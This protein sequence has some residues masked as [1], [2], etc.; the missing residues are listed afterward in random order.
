[1]SKKCLSLVLVLS[2]VLQL[3]CMIPAMATETTEPEVIRT[4]IVNDSF[5]TGLDGWVYGPGTIREGS[6]DWDENGYMV[7]TRTTEAS[8][9]ANT[10]TMVKADRDFAD[11]ALEGNK[12]VIEARVKT[13]GNESGANNARLR[14]NLPVEEKYI[15][16]SDTVNYL[17]WAGGTIAH[18]DATDSTVKY[19]NS[20][21]STA[22]LMENVAADEWVNI[23]A[24]IDGTDGNLQNYT[25]SA[26]KDNDEANAVT[27]TG[28]SLKEFKNQIYDAENALDGNETTATMYTALE[29]LNFTLNS[30]ASSITVD[31]IRAYTEKEV[32]DAT[33]TIV[34]GILLDTTDAINIQFN[35]TAAI[36]SL[37]EGAVTVEG[38]EGPAFFNPE[39]KILN[40]TPAETL[41][42]GKEYTVTFDREALREAG[43]NL[44][45]K[46]TLKFKAKGY[47]VTYF[48]DDDFNANGDIGNWK[49]VYGTETGKNITLKQTN[50]EDGTGVMEFASDRYSARTTTTSPTISSNFKDINFTGAEEI[51]IETRFMATG[52]VDSSEVAG[53]LGYFKFNQ[54]EDKSLA[55]ITP[56]SNGGG[57]LGSQGGTLIAIK[58]TGFEYKKTNGYTTGNANSNLA[59]GEW[60]N[61]KIVMTPNEGTYGTYSITTWA[62]GKE[63]EAVTMTD[64]TMQ[65]N[66]IAFYDPQAYVDNGSSNEGLTATKH[67]ALKNLLYVI[68]KYSNTYYIDYIKGY[69]ELAPEMTMSA[70]LKASLI[71]NAAPVVF[72]I[73][74][75]DDITAIPAGAFTIDG[76]DLAESFDANAKTLTLTPE[77][78][79]AKGA[80]YTVNVDA[81]ALYNAGIDYTGAETF[82]I[83]TIGMGKNYL[84]N[85]NFDTEGNLG[86]WVIGD[87]SAESGK[88]VT[89]SQKTVDGNG[90][91]SLASDR[92]STLTSYNTPSVFNDIDDTKLA[93]NKIVI[94]T[95]IKALGGT[96]SAG[97]AGNMVDLHLN[98]PNDVNYLGDNSNHNYVGWAGGTMLRL[99]GLNATDISNVG[100]KSTDAPYA[101]KALSS[102][103]GYNQWVNVKI[104]LDKTTSKYDITIWEDGKED[105][106]I[107]KVNTAGEYATLKEYRQAH[108]DIENFRDAELAGTLD[109]YTYKTYH[110][111][112]KSLSFSMPKWSNELLVD[113]FKAYIEVEPTETVSAEIAEKLIATTDAVNVKLTASTAI[114][115]LPE[116]VAAINGVEATESF[117]AATQTLTLTPAAELTKG[118]AYTVTVNTDALYDAGYKYTGETSLS[119]RTIGVGTN[120]FLNDDFNTAGD[121]GNWKLV[122]GTEGGKNITFQQTTMPD[123]TGVMEFG[124]D[125]YSSAATTSSPTI[126]ND[127]A[128]IDLDTNRIVIETRYKSVGGGTKANGDA[129][130][131]HYFKFNQP[132]D[133]SLAGYSAAGGYLG[134]NGGTLIEQTQD[135]VKYKS[136]AYSTSIHDANLVAGEWINAK[137]VID[138]T[139]GVY[140]DYTLTTWEDGNVANAVTTTGTMNENGNYYYNP[141]LFKDEDT[142]NDWTRHK[143][144]QNLLFVL[145]EYSDTMY[146]DYVKAGIVVD[147]NVRATIDCG[148]TVEV[149]QPINVKFVSEDAIES[150]PA[151]AVTIAGVETTNVFDA[152]TQTLTVTPDT[153]LTEGTTY[154]LTV[155]EDVL[156]A[157]AEGL[158]LTGVKTFNIRARGERETG[159]VISD[160]FNDGTT[161]GWTIGAANDAYKAGMDV[162]DVDGEEGNKA[163]KVTMSAIAAGDGNQPNVT[164]VLGNGIDLKD[165]E[166][167]TINTRI[168]RTD[169]LNYYLKANR[170]DEISQVLHEYEWSAYTLMGAE[171]KVQ[172]VTSTGALGGVDGAYTYRPSDPN[173]AAIPSEWVTYTITFK[174]E[175]GCYWISA[176]LDDG[177]VI[178]NERV[179]A[180]YVA[181]TALEKMFGTTPV[182]N[183]GYD[184]LDS[185][186]FVPMAGCTGELLIDYVNVSITNTN[187][188]AES[189]LTVG[190]EVIEEI[191]AGTTVKPQ[192]TV[193]EE[194]SY[195]LI[196]A[197][198]IDGVLEDTHINPVTVTADGLNYT[199]EDGYAIPSALE[200]KYEIKAFV[201]NAIDGLK[202]V[203]TVAQAESAAND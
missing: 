139:D 173:G 96:D 175:T 100:Y 93:D 74:T 43:I 148:P 135:G 132:E 95:R 58:D 198:Y 12:I 141:T 155:N 82:T 72:N 134:A 156:E 178:T 112:M 203:S 158:V 14:M 200:G 76:V 21:Y 1:M 84:I 36:T 6:L 117:D 126:S 130:S 63:D 45:G 153:T 2:M 180:I 30:N 170:P 49:L 183:A 99:G 64:G 26:W 9:T 35:T 162:V 124:A 53:T 185:L 168:K 4:Y 80:T 189:A 147:Y 177:T 119:F 24:V 187:V 125:R 150:V 154:V 108:Y 192:F 65:E 169:G 55:G 57:Y 68:D 28:G 78:E 120:Y 90:V 31:Y 89:L 171:T 62:D 145:R 27:T 165:G 60:I 34:G 146:I 56:P 161:E 81:T 103:M 111:F 193:N 190:G 7:L 118:T 19:K 105:E 115:A 13:T 131:R 159:K 61:A 172:T 79:L 22:A 44:L 106:A 196:S 92:Y 160:D 86:D 94:E 39:T 25:I 123:G 85:D 77:A 202:P 38:V 129:G 73:V 195:A 41:T 5:D 140:S 17:G 121:L 71:D 70:T 127:F 188:I 52:G 137:I 109:S 11:V 167:V 67:T 176:A 194:G 37:P 33:A 46:E 69:T 199:E 133:K 83:K 42:A 51:V 88:T 101:T 50:L 32:T 201:W 16:Y 151:N 191:T 40:I 163:L 66:A 144:L 107:V 174:P 166:W 116:G 3:V 142:T 104:T 179:G 18:F 8:D 98:R 143:T 181:G 54:P 164:R 114:T 149:G 152:E 122:Y 128:D 197:L 182:G 15:T 136:G 47:G 110:E 102:T 138:N 10:N 59:A 29:S 97:N 48:I 184:F 23:K 91:M 87:M 186:T 20:S 113:Y 157:S 75:E